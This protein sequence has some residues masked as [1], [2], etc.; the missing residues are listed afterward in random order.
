[1]E[2]EPG[3]PIYANLMCCATELRIYC[4]S[5]DNFG[6]HQKAPLNSGFQVVSLMR[7]IRDRS[8]VRLG[9]FYSPGPA[10]PWVGI[11][12]VPALKALA[13]LQESSLASPLSTGSGICFLPLSLQT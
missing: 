9:I 6:L 8:G 1:M 4:L 7:R 10:R 2:I 12:C 5:A 3:G 13:P 11:G